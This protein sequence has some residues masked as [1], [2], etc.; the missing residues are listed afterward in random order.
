VL[1]IGGMLAYGALPGGDG[2]QRGAG[3]ANQIAPPVRIASAETRSIPVMTRTI[4]TV[5]ANATVEIKS[6]TDGELIAVEF[7]EGQLVKKGDILFRIDPLPAQAELR[8]AEAQVARVQA[9]LASAQSDADR[10]A[11]L[12]ER[13]IVSMQQ[14]DQ[15]VAEA[16]A[17][18]A[19]QA[20]DQAALERARLNLGY[21]TIRAPMDGKTGPYLIYPGNLVRGNT[22]A[23]VVLNQVQPVKISFFLPQDQLPALQ[24]RMREGAL[25]ASLA[26]HSETTVAQALLDE[27]DIVVDVDFIGNVVDERSGTI[28]LRA[29]FDNPDFRLVPGELVDVNVELD[30]LR[31]TIVVPR[32]A[33]NIGQDGGYYVFVVGADSSVEMRPVT[34]QYQDETFASVG[35]VIQPGERVVIDGQLRLTPG[36]Q[37]AIMDDAPRVPAVGE[38]Q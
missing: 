5:M 20:A 4:G 1:L 13:G 11:A 24:A 22:D 33:I 18:T 26:V 30:V 8:Q 15:M 19:T 27:T 6:Q 34:V 3:G 2:A 17:L 28:E 37:V 16:R 38:A 25:R 31:D 14:R 12:A 21:T 7:Q 29:T 23:L 10:A 32:A 36:I 35:N 9:Q